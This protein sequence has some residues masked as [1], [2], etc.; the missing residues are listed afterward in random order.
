MSSTPEP[1]KRLEI[2]LS[3]ALRALSHQ[4]SLLD[5]LRSRATLLTTAAAL[6]ISFPVVSSVRRAEIGVSAGVAAVA[7]VGVLMCTLVICAPWWHW[8][9]RSSAGQLLLAVDEG[10]DLD[11]LRRHL[12]KDFERWLDDNERK[13]GILQW[14]FTAGLLMLGLEVA[15]WAFQL[16]VTVH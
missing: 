11:S 6:V 9:F 1:D 2:V 8:K 7:L 13:I 4:Q 12:A 16:A 10:H 14:W 3:E 5:N 15:A